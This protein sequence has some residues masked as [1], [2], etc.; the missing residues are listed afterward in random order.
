MSEN[1]QEQQ[2][3]VTLETL[4]SLCK[5]RGFIFPGSEIY[6][7]LA[8]TYDYGPLGIELKRNIRDAWWRSMVYERDDVEGIES[9]ILMNPRT[10]KASGHVDTFSDPLCD[11]LGPS[12]KRYRADH[13]PPVEATAFEVIDISDEAAP[14]K[15]ENSQIWASSK[16]K[17]KEFYQAYWEKSLG[18][19]GKRVKLEEVPGS[20]RV[21][22]FS[23]DDGGLLTEPRAFNLMLTT[24]CGPV[25]ES[26]AQVFLRPETAQGMFVNFANVQSSMR[27]KLPFGI[28]QNGKSFR[29]EITPKNF[30]FRTR[31]FEQMELEFFCKPGEECREGE[32]NDDQWWEHWVEYRTNWHVRYGLKREHLRFHY[33]SR[34]ELA[35]YSKACCD[36]EFL[37]PLG[38]QELEGIAN[39]TNYDLSQHMKES[40]KDLRYFD[41]ELNKHYVP[42]VIEPAL[43]ADRSC[44]AF[45]TDAYTEEQVRDDK[46]VVLKLHRDLAPVK[47][48][49]FPLLKNKP[50]LVAMAEKLTMDLKKKFHTVYDDTAAIG[51]LYRR[52]D[53][54]GTPYC[55]TVDVDSLTD[56]AVT[57]RDRDTMQQV[58]L[59][60]DKVRDHIAG[61]LLAAR[62]NA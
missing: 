19:A 46:R 47:C 44:L 14:R 2:C 35:H 27:R 29:N 48:A 4:V 49:V 40:G 42:Y 33:Q 59:P 13:V 62:E 30:I 18:L 17:A 9:A 7:G 11:S 22:R 34:E 56:Q 39:R 41:A 43:G 16:K 36:I 28:A 45:L 6:D 12:H 58:R 32:M 61:E 31:E 51:K 25:V 3:H 10:W 53:E 50:E 21:G 57:V 26:A 20:T 24:H 37:F 55:I 23:P 1:A 8:G 54:I 38:W 15:V 52:Q 5:R 60:I